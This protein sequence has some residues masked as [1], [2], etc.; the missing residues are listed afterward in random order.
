M[1]DAK[2]GPHLDA[3]AER[4]EARHDLETCYFDL[5][6]AATDRRLGSIPGRCNHFIVLS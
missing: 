3:V 1:K 5:K 2:F 4:L 6:H